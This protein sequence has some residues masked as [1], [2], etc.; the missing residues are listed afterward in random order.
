MASEL[1]KVKKLYAECGK[2]PAKCDYERNHKLVDSTYTGHKKIK[3]EEYIKIMD[4]NYGSCTN[5]GNPY[6]KIK[7]WI[8]TG[9]LNYSECSEWANDIEANFEL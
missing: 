8:K 9:V 7:E 1:R 6:T 4:E 5:E 3:A 2:N